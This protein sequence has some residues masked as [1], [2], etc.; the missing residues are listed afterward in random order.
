[1]VKREYSMPFNIRSV[2]GAT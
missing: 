1:M 2:I